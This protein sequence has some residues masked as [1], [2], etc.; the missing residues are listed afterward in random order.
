MIYIIISIIGLLVIVALF[1]YTS[2]S[3]DKENEPPVEAPPAD[4]CGAH[5]ICEKGLKKID[6]NIEY[7]DDEELDQYKGIPSD[8]FNDQQIDQFREIL[9]TIR[10]EELSDWFIS[11]EKRG[12]ELPD[13]LKQE[14]N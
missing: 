9:Y 4:C 5:A 10:P 7:F 14:L 3:K 13:V 2:K 1:T 8:R 12:I 11:L 6:M